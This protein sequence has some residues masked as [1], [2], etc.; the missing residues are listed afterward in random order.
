M[1]RVLNLGQNARTQKL[2]YGKVRQPLD[3]QGWF[4]QARFGMFI[5]L[6]SY[7]LKG[8]EASWPLA[9]GQ[10]SYADYEALAEHIT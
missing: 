10:I 7:S 9:W 6:G 1:D 5:H 2:K 4:E 3:K 8:M